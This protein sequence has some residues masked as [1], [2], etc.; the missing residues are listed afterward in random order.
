MLKTKEIITAII[1]SVASG[2]SMQAAAGEIEPGWYVGADFGHA[3]IE[4]EGQAFYRDKD[5]SDTAFSLHSGYRVNSYFAIEAA[6]ADLGDY[7]YRAELYSEIFVPRILHQ[8]EII[9]SGRRLDLALV[10]N[11]PLGERFEAYAKAGFANTEVESEFRSIDD[12]FQSKDS[13]TDA[14]Y[15]VGLRFHFDAPWSLRLQ[16][17]RTQLGDYE[18]DIDALWLGAEY[19]FSSR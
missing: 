6:Y 10:A 18:S 9:I 7:S 13:S 5:F 4:P 2:F 8:Y 19:R 16:W 17:D 11:I 3:E 12:N 14:F 15:G 1:V